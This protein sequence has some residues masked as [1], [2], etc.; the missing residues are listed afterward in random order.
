VKALLVAA[1]LI[2]GTI[3]CQRSISPP[4]SK[5]DYSHVKKDIMGES[6]ATFLSNNPNCRFDLPDDMYSGS[7]SKLCVLVDGEYM[8][9]KPAQITYAG[10]P[11][12][13]QARFY[14]DALFNLAFTTLKTDDCKTYHILDV[15]KEKYGEPKETRSV[16]GKEIRPAE[17]SEKNPF[18]FWQDGTITIA[19]NDAL[20]CDATFEIDKTVDVVTKAKN[21]ADAEKDRSQHQSQKSDM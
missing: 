3:A 11:V 14:K 2:I 18:L 20:T 10:M 12:T 15:L 4:Q 1:V 21:A 7:G 9:G 16:N 8:K 13:I 17:F 6:V 19:Y 5:P